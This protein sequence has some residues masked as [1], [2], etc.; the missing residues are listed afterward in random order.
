MK[1]RIISLIVLTALVVVSCMPA[2]ALADGQNNRF[3][4]VS[5]DPA[6]WTF[7]GGDISAN[8]D[9]KTIYCGTFNPRKAVYNKR[10]M[11]GDFVLTAGINVGGG[12]NGNCIILKVGS[13]NIKFGGGK[14]VYLGDT[15]KGQ[16]TSKGGL[17]KIAAVYKSSGYVALYN[18]ED[19][20]QQLVFEQSGASLANLNDSNLELEFSWTSGSV[21]D[22][23][24]Y[25]P[26]GEVFEDN[27][28]N[29]SALDDDWYFADG[30]YAATD[31][32]S[33]NFR[34]TADGN[35]DSIA[36]IKPA[37]ANGKYSVSMDIAQGEAD[38]NYI[39]FN[40]ITDSDFYA[41]KIDGGNCSVL[42]GADELAAASF[43]GELKNVRIDVSAENDGDIEVYVNNSDTALLCANDTSYS[44]G[45]VGVCLGAQT[46]VDNV[47]VEVIDNSPE[48]R[49]KKAVKVF[50]ADKTADKLKNIVNTYHEQLGVDI[51]DLDALGGENT[52]KIFE[53]ALGALSEKTTPKEIADAVNSRVAFALISQTGDVNVLLKYENYIV[54]ED[55]AYYDDWSTMAE[56]EKEQ[57]CLKLKGVSDA[58]ILAQF[59]SRV[60]L[61]ALADT[62]WSGMKNKLEYYNASISADIAAAD[63]TSAEAQKKIYTEFKDALTNGGIDSIS[64]IPGK[65]DE[66]VD[67]YKSYG[68]DSGGSSGGGSSKRGGGGSSGGKSYTVPVTEPKENTT[69]IPSL[70]FGDIADIDWAVTPI[71]KLWQDGIVTGK[72]EK[73]FA[74]YD[75]VTREEFVAIIVRV[76]KLASDSTDSGFTDV[77]DGRWSAG[78]ITAAKKAGIISGINDKLFAPTDKITRQ[79]MALIAMRA[80][81]ILVI[82]FKDGTLAYADKDDI[83]QYAK[84]AV[85]SLSEAKIINGANG[86]FE[87]M[88]YANRAQTAAVVY[89][90]LQAMN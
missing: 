90:L 2:F 3:I 46:A 78:A 26:F 18:I 23:R 85:A 10:V 50:N 86:R 58:E 47:C 70:P 83:A 31:D 89:R 11:D 8:A 42:K 75:D 66:L 72:S 45:R 84:D 9:S 52:D 16:Y 40:S 17:V 43:D 77:A 87:P 32:G 61:C 6:D 22:I 24:M 37:F 5:F 4:Q 56:S 14:T 65:L 21:Q 69:E 63:K 79:D 80:G 74:P 1:N 49:L 36:Y 68:E 53:S 7:D 20:S 57:I 28:D 73:T 67:K 51:G 15:E 27:F 48:G 35:T 41:L 54:S 44:M 71:V 55:K 12:G 82:E 19:G 33:G 34:L 81:E 39:Y 30:A 62:E 25:K 38:V 59:E 64:D 76:L 88:G 13:L 29:G 60:I